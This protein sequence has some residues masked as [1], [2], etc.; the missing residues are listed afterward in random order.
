M[1]GREALEI[2]DR[3]NNRGAASN[4]EIGELIFSVFTHKR[5]V[6]QESLEKRLGN[7]D[8]NRKRNKDGFN[9]LKAVY[10]DAIDLRRLIQNLRAVYLSTPDP[11]GKNGFDKDDYTKIQKIIDS[12]LGKWIAI[13]TKGVFWL[14]DEV[15]NQIL[16]FILVI[17]DIAGYDLDK[18]APMVLQLANT[19]TS[20]VHFITG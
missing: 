1:G 8:R 7:I 16:A 3:R 12:S 20:E 2:L 10:E 15:S 11:L 5:R 19:D 4:K 14:S 6:G 9:A 17:L 18:K 13:K